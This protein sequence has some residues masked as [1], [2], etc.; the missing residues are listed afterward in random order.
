[1]NNYVCLYKVKY[2]NLEEAPTLDCGLFYASSFT[3]AIQQL[4]GNIYGTDLISIEYLCLYDT[5]ATFSEKL[6]EEVR[7]EIEAR[8]A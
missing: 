2:L 6:F 8:Y 3:D 5:I 1:M 4:E 7:A